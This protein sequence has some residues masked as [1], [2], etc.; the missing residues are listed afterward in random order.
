MSTGDHWTP[1]SSS[2]NIAYDNP[3]T[4]VRH[5]EDAF[6]AMEPAHQSQMP[7]TVKSPIFGPVAERKQFGFDREFS[8]IPIPTR[9]HIT[10]SPNFEIEYDLDGVGTEGAKNIELWI[11]QNEGRTWELYGSDPDRVSPAQVRLKQEG[12]YGFRF[13]VEGFNGAVPSPPKNNT[14]PDIWV[15][16]DWT[17]PEGRITRATVEA[18]RFVDASGIGTRQPEMLIE[19]VAEDALLHEQPI[20]ISYGGAPDGPWNRIAGPI[21]NSGS[22]RWSFPNSLPARTFLRLE[23]RDVAGNVTSSVFEASKASHHG[24]AVAR[25]RGIRPLPREA[26]RPIRYR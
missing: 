21:H 19:W 18:D 20:T 5:T 11:T 23:V 4:D 12:L 14:R 17:R 9:P 15:A 13:L 7:T 1:A 16:A 25:P 8:G 3:F 10:A 2:K 26:R 24:P 6:G 22:Y